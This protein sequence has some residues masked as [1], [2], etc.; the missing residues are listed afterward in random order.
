M[1]LHNLINRLLL[2][3]VRKFGSCICENTGY[4]DLTSNK[5][6]LILLYYQNETFSSY[7]CYEL[8]SAYPNTNL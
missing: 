7:Y 6:V 2:R 4:I 3:N 8:H 5:R 1:S